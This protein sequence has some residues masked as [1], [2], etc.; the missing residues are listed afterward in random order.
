MTTQFKKALEAVEALET[1]LCEL[2]VRSCM[3]PYAA[4]HTLLQ[5]QTQALPKPF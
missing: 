2:K 4:G 1:H 5:T 3:H